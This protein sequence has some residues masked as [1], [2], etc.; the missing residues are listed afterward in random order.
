MSNSRLSNIVVAAIVAAAVALGTAK[1]TANH[2]TA[3]M[4]PAAKGTLE[5]VLSTG[6]IR[7]GY[8]VQP[9]NFIKDPETKKISGIFPEVLEKAAGILGVKVEW[10]EE[11]A[12][13]TMI[14]GL[15]AGRYD[16]IGSPVWPTGQRARVADFTEAVHYNGVE[17]YVRA[18]DTRYDANIGTLN[19]AQFSIA[20]MDGEAAV[21]IAQEDFP[22]AK[23]VSLPQ[24]SDLSQLMLT[25]VT[26]KADATFMDSIIAQQ[27]IDKNPGKL[28]PARAGLPV[29]LFANVMMMKQTD[30]AF[31]RALDTAIAGLQNNGVVDQITKKYEPFPGAYYRK[32]RPFQEPK[33]N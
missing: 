32:A 9:P 19:D 25:V 17:M 1:Y 15:Q 20:V 29:R 33:G 4:A 5:K 22:K 24:L 23:T 30:D 6:V 13:G 7:C 10:T 14:E 18:D 3:G 31:R 11:V 27:F 2:G 26:R 8:V 28:K 16:L 12:W 21:A